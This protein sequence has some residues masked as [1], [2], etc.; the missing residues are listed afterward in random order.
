MLS[1]SRLS[2]AMLARVLLRAVKTQRFRTYRRISWLK[3]GV[4]GEITK[5]LSRKKN[6]TF[7]VS[8]HL[9][10]GKSL[11]ILSNFNCINV[12][13]SVSEKSVLSSTFNAKSVFRTV[14]ARWRDCVVKDY[15]MMKSTIVIFVQVLMYCPWNKH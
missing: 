5:K 12:F 1:A 13:S 7:P 4:L 15:Q 6:S 3:E 11:K 9:V 10:N 2:T 14:L 8:L